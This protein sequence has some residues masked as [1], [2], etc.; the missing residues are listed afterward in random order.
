MKNYTMD[1]L[2]SPLSNQSDL[3]LKNNTVL[4]Y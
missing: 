3:T 4:E 2:S 1:P